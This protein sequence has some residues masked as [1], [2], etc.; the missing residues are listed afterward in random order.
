MLQFMKRYDCYSLLNVT[1]V[2]V[3]GTLRLLQFVEGSIPLFPFVHN[4]VSE[5]W[6]FTCT[7]V[8]HNNKFGACTSHC[9]V[10]VTCT[11]KS[12]TTQI[13][14]A[15]AFERSDVSMMVHYD[16]VVV[17]FDLFCFEPLQKVK[18]HPF[19]YWYLLL[20]WLVD[21]EWKRRTSQVAHY[22]VGTNTYTSIL[23]QHG[24]MRREILT[25]CSFAGKVNTL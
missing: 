19:A 20:Q 10:V 15:R 1:N 17:C 5:E 14:D 11:C 13:N 21:Q 3:Y 22:T 8:V 6:W 9:V 16:C 24:T 18:L 23:D 4:D 7:I 12:V 25:G 2:I